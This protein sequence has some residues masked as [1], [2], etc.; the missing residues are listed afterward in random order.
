MDWQNP[1]KY[2]EQLEALGYA[3]E[4]LHGKNDVGVLSG[5][6]S[7][8]TE[9]VDAITKDNSAIGIKHTCV[10]LCDTLDIEAVSTARICALALTDMG[11]RAL[12][13]FDAPIDEII[14]ALDQGCSAVIILSENVTRNLF[15]TRM[16]VQ[17]GQSTVAA[18]SCR[19]RAT[20]WRSS[21]LA[22]RHSSVSS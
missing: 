8:C 9:C 11:E 5:L 10:I 19:C 7:K 1:T 4:L 14:D 21:S 13:G 12:V 18:S 15:F 16:L 2:T 6:V 22:T 17:L 20:S 3:S